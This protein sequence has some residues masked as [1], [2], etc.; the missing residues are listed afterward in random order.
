MK[1]YVTVRPRAKKEEVV[2]LDATHFKI[3]VKEP[4]VDGKAN[5]AVGR[6]LARY[7]EV[8][9]SRMILL[10]GERQLRRGE[11]VTLEQLEHEL[12]R[13][14]LKRSEKTA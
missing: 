10:K 1:Y 3:A 13:H 9:F 5:E 8:P 7:L 12:D 2:Q 6:A 11:F 4:P 14:R